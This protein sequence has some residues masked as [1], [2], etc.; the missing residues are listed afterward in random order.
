MSQLTELPSI[1]ELIHNNKTFRFVSELDYINYNNK[2]DYPDI[3]D[4]NDNDNEN[5]RK[6]DLLILANQVF[7]GITNS[8]IQET[9]TEKLNNTLSKVKTLML[10]RPF[11]K[12]NDVQKKGIIETYFKSKHPSFNDDKINKM[13][14]QIIN[15]IAEKKLVTKN[16]DY[17]K[18]VSKLNNIIGIVIVDDNIEI[19]EKKKK[20]AKKQKED[21]TE[22]EE[23][24]KSVK[25][26]KVAKKTKTSTD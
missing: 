22:K 24:K 19:E 25:K 3:N 20:I 10:K 15:M 23:K 4:I 2:K 12:L 1:H 17:D 5:K 21:L 6:Q 26:E 11:Y 16:F 13:V 14:L 8:N 7:K 9:Q 18:D